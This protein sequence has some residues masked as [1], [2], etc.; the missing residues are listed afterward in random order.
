MSSYLLPAFRVHNMIQ[1]LHGHKDK[2]KKSD[3]FAYIRELHLP[4]PFCV[5]HT[6]YL[7]VNKGGESLIKS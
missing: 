7:V 4:R 6:Q 5:V 2:E 3:E 1:G